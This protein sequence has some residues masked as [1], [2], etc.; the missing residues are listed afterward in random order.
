MSA[1]HKTRPQSLSRGAHP[2]QPAWTGSG[3]GEERSVTIV[4]KKL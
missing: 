1:E 2:A 4:I 3:G